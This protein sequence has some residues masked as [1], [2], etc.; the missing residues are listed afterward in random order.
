[1]FLTKINLVA[2]NHSTYHINESVMLCN[3]LIDA[4]RYNGQIIGREI[5]ITYYFSNENLLTF[6]INVN[7]PEQ[8]SLD[9]RHNSAF[10]I[11]ALDKLAK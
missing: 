3:Q 5:P 2:K 6:E 7:C 9:S 11:A 10:V 4:W 1:M 8:D